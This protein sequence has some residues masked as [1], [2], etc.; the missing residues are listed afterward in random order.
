MLGTLNPS[1]TLGQTGLGR[2]VINT[3]NPSPTRTGLGRIVYA[4]I[5]R[6][7]KCMRMRV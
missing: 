2:K 6:T 4:N 1:P 7:L 5:L 3:L